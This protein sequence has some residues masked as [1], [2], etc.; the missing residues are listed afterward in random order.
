MSVLA[1]CPGIVVGIDVSAAC[2]AAVGWVVAE[3]TMRN[4]GL[5]L[6]HACPPSSTTDL[7]R[8]P[9]LVGIDGSEVSELATALAFDEASRRRVDLVALHTWM[10]IGVF[11]DRKPDHSTLD[12]ATEA[13]R[14]LVEGD[15]PV[16]C[17]VRVAP[18]TEKTTTTTTIP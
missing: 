15:Y 17:H 7:Q 3:A 8:A 11:L 18:S 14:G 9:V 6:I 10:D 13:S 12:S 4:I 2:D 1:D 5:S 16:H